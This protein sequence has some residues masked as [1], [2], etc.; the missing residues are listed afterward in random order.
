MP[1]NRGKGG[2]LRRVEVEELDVL[3]FSR[4]GTFRSLLHPS[5]TKLGKSPIGFWPGQLL[6]NISGHT[7]EISVCDLKPR[8]P[9]V[10]VTERHFFSEELILPLDGDV[11]IHVGEPTGDG[12]P[13]VDRIR[14][15]R[16]PQGT[17]V[18]LRRGV[19]HHAP[20]ADQ[21]THVLILLNELTYSIDC[22][23]VA[24]PKSRQMRIVEKPAGLVDGDAGASA[25]SSGDAESG[26]PP[27]MP[28]AT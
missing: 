10:D 18:V 17:A 25:H 12:S 1:K 2:G 22:P 15:F 20:F 4:Y 16:V 9:I 23:V 28:P 19:W 11:I 13:P 26:E 24:L 21:S 8:K 6:M 27:E 5:G 3:D 7:V 14:A